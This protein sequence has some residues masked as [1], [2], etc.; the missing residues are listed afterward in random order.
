M[1]NISFD[2]FK[3]LDIRIAEIKSAEKVAGTDKLLKLK[4]MIG[5]EE[6]QTITSIAKDYSPEELIGKKIVV[7]TNLEP[8]TIRGEKS[9][10]MLLAALEGDKVVL[11]VPDKDISSGISV[12]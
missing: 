6:R 7:L 3:K 8:R 4:I 5:N 12:S 2:E 1:E 11:L 10:G 9:E